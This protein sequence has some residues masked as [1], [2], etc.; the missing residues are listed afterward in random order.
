MFRGYPFSKATYYRRKKRA[1][2]L[3]CSILDLPDNRGKHK[4]HAKGR[5]HP[6]KATIGDRHISSH[7]YVKIYVG[8]DHH[9]A[10]KIG[11][12][13]EHI[14]VWIENGNLLPAGYVLHHID[15][16]QTNNHIENLSLLTPSQHTSHHNKL[17]KRKKAK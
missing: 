6:R 13:Y 9:L 3:G 2:I 17:R 14:F 10:D 7:G 12:A 11:H 4:N 8:K 16:D 5:K 1:E 15:G